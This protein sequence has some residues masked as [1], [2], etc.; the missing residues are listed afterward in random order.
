[1]I[2]LTQEMRERINNALANRTPCILATASATGEPSLGYKG[3]MM[4]FDD[5]HLAYW[6]RARLGLLE[7]IEQ[8]PKI[9]VLYSDLAARVHWR[10]QGGATVYKTGRFRE[11]IMAR[12]IQAELDRDPERKGYGVVLRV[13]GAQRLWGGDAR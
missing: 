9:T 5:E 8:N 12:T 6:E 7:H 2:H 3:S 10:F 4:V 13:P 1:M 11:Q